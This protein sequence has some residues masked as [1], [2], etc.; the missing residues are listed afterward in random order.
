MSFADEVLAARERPGPRC[1]FYHLNF[2]T[3]DRADLDTA[4][5]E[6]FIPT[7]V[8]HRAMKARGVDIGDQTVARHRKG[9]CSCPARQAA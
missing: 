2:D 5:D 8:I 7:A 6:P 4:L 1:T 3:A 9:D